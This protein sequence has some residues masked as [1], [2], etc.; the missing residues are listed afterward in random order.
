MIAYRVLPWLS[1][2]AGFSVQWAELKS[3]AAINNVIDS[4]PDGRMNYKDTNFGF[5]GNF[6]ALFEI[7]Q[8]TRVGITYRSQVDQSFHDVPSFAQIGPGLKAALSAPA[9]SATTSAST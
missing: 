1:L 6:G 9:C 7:N 3:G 2:G 5:G 4:L 8:R